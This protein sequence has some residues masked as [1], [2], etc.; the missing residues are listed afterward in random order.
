MIARLS[1]EVHACIPTL[2]LLRQHYW[3]ALHNWLS[4]IQEASLQPQ[5]SSYCSIYCYS[6][7][8]HH[9]TVIVFHSF[10]FGAVTGAPDI[11]AVNCRLSIGFAVGGGGMPMAEA[12]C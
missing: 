6:I 8:K 1:V 10:A 5:G 11:Y 12:C 3:S 7:L 4:H 9:P 2:P